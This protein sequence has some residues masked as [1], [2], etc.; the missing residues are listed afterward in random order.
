M[1]YLSPKTVSCQLYCC[2]LKGFS[3]AIQSGTQDP[4][5]A[6]G[7]G[8]NCGTGSASGYCPANGD[9]IVVVLFSGAARALRIDTNRGQLSLGT[10]GSTFGHNAGA[11]TVS[12]A[13]TDWNSAKT[14][15]KP[16]TGSANPDEFFSSDGPRKIFYNPDGSAITANNFLFGTN[17]GTTLQK[18]DITAADGISTKTGSAQNQTTPG[19]PFIPFF[20]TSAAAPHAAAIAALIKSAKPSYTPAQIKTAMTSTALDNGAAG[21]DRDGGFG[22]VMALQAVQYALAH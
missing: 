21:W 20:G 19:S 9:Q 7:Q 22:V 6:I 4:Y 8:T 14:G 10:P 1:L 3:A 17:G 15:T 13:A 11:N 18:P 12:V 16:F 2:P 5:E